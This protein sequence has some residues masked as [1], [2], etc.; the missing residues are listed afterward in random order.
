MLDNLPISR[1]RIGS[2]ALQLSYQTKRNKL[3]YGVL[4][5]SRLSA[6]ERTIGA[7][8]GIGAGE[9]LFGKDASPFG[10]IYRA[11]TDTVAIRRVSLGANGLQLPVQ[12]PGISLADYAAL[13][14]FVAKER[15]DVSK[16]VMEKLIS[17]VEMVRE[18]HVPEPKI[19][20]PDP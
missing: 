2:R 12:V 18:A 19:L 17:L 7:G 16:K 1:C 10:T 5:I 9:F 20:N 15:S 8:N 3:A 13:M 4:G 11:K 6:L 14:R